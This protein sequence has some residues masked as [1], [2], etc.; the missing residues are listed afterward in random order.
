[1]FAEWI[2]AKS[3]APIALKLA[4]KIAEVS[5]NPIGRKIGELKL[6]FEVGIN[7]Y[8]RHQID[9]YS[10]IKTIIRPS[11]PL[12]IEDIYVNLYAVEDS[13]FGVKKAIRTGKDSN[14]FRDDQFIDMI[15]SKKHLIITATAGAG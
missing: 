15:D 14:I 13:V 1:M 3:I 5:K 11:N 9:R 8:V 4:P 12:S 6:Y 7:D 10:K 2:T